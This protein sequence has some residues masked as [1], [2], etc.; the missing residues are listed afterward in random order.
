MQAQKNVICNMFLPLQEMSRT[1]R[2][3]IFCQAAFSEGVW[4]LATEVMNM[5]EDGQL[6]GQKLS[7]KNLLTT[8]EFK[9]QH[10]Q[11][12][13]HLDPLY[14]QRMLQ[15]LVDRDQSLSEMKEACSK[16][17]SLSILKTSFVRC[18]N[19]RNWEDAVSRF[20]L[21]AVESRLS[22]FQ[23]LSF[24]KGIPQVFR[25]YCQAALS[26]RNAQAVDCYTVTCNEIKGYVIQADTTV[27]TAERIKEAVS[28]YQGANI[29]VAHIPKV[30]VIFHLDKQ[31]ELY[32]LCNIVINFASDRSGPKTNWR[33]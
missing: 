17:R 11:P 2:D 28:T 21:F 6:K 12:L 10:F 15:Q 26:S 22:Q 14:Q 30:L 19:V 33:A 5:Y 16:H 25:D 27:L 29:I 1:T 20:S 3:N 8:P 31:F 7:R 24:N 4:S 18:T 9:Q 13:H 23:H 32:M